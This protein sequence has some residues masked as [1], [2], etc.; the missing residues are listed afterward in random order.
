[1]TR[2]KL[3]KQAVNTE[4]EEKLAKVKYRPEGYHTDHDREAAAFLFGYG[5]GYRR[6]SWI[7]N[8]PESTVREWLRQYKKGKFK[9]TLKP[10][11][12]PYDPA[13]R[14]KVIEMRNSG[15]KWHDI[16]EETGVSLSSCLKWMT[17][18]KKKAAESQTEQQ[19]EQS[20]EQS[21]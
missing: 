5:I 6:V 7:L 15:M 12:F 9:G 20:A 3:D 18:Y 8:L 19:I 2:K 16:T 21:D 13:L 4:E 17:E 10:H 14:E 11:A 1:M